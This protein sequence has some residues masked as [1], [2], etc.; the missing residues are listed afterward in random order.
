MPTEFLKFEDLLECYA[1]IGESLVAAVPE[2]WSSITH[3][4]LLDGDALTQQTVYQPT[5]L[6]KSTK[7]I[8]VQEPWDFDYAFLDLAELTS[9]KERGLYRKLIYRLQADGSYEV[10]IDYDADLEAEILAME[11][12]E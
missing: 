3:T 7:G 1:F 4:A 12:N 10:D 6:K 8:V 9:D 11:S 2:P 5:D